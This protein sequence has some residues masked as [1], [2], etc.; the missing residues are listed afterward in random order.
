MMR[1]CGIVLLIALVGSA[2]GAE[3]LRIATFQADVTPPLGAPL[4]FGAYG[5]ARELVDPLSARGLV[6]LSDEQPVVLCAVDWIGLRNGGQQAFCEA[7]A[8]AAG[9]TTERVNVH[10]LHQHDAPGVDFSSEERLSA[11]GRGGTTCDVA[12][13]RQAIAA[14]ARA[15]GDAVRD[16]PRAVTHLGIGKAKV[17]RVAS[18]RRIIGPDGKSKA[19]RWSATKNA[20]VRAEPEGLIDPWLQLLSFWDGD[21]PIASVTYYATHPQ[22]YYGKGGVSCDFPGLARGLRESA[23]PGVAHIHFNGAG[24]NVTAGKYNDG[25]PTNRMA[26]AERLADGMQRAWLATVKASI[27]AGDVDYRAEA[28]ELPSGG[29]LPAG[30]TF[31][32][33]ALRLG[34]AWIIHTPGE[35]FVEY[36]LAAQRMR[37]AATVCMA[38]YGDLAPGYIGTAKAYDEGGYEPGNSRTTPEAEQVLL[39]CF[40]RLLRD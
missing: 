29:R 36:Q 13:S 32:V 4:G 15:L 12:A 27:V 34:S 25:N 31:D 17:E 37:P 2:A 10:C 39:D 18:N 7:L 38:A 1:R 5:V 28:I 30:R 3:P 35:L 9:T 33:T 11:A 20:D 23:L 40:R 26:L 21:T 14:T 19:V 8:A 6:I 24:G 16:R 22:S